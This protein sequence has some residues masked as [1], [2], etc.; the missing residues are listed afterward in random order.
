[1]LL[2]VL[3]VGD[4]CGEGGQDI[5]ARRLKELR[6]AEDIHFTVVNG[7]NAASNGLMPQQA[8]DTAGPC[9]LPGFCPVQ[10]GQRH[11]GRRAFFRP[12]H[13]LHGVRRGGVPPNFR[14]ARRPHR[15]PCA[16]HRAG[17]GHAL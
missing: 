9:G 6:E 5:L 3:A 8:R 16:L 14:K 1:M 10:Q 7:E 15:R 12:P 17:A 11:P 4:V 2:N 13:R